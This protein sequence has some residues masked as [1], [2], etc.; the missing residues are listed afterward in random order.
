MTVE[1]KK[2]KL[3]VG[4]F[5]GEVA[6]LRRERRAGTATALTRTNLLALSARIYTL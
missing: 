3:G 6:V 2:V 1:K 5:F 4:H